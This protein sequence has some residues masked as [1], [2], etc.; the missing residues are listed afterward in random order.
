MAPI[1]RAPIDPHGTKRRKKQQANTSISRYNQS[2][3]PF[4]PYYRVDY[5]K[6]RRVRNGE[7]DP[8]G[9]VHDG[10]WPGGSKAK[11]CPRVIRLGQHAI[12]LV[13]PTIYK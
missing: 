9:S 3:G 12:R 4:F 5:A 8:C 2:V 6:K 1:D 7:N 11:H 10:R 13:R